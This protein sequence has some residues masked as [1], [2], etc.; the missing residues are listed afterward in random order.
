MSSA[1]KPVQPSRRL[2]LIGGTGR[3]GSAIARVLRASH[4]HL[5]I[6]I[7]G[8]HRQRAQALIDDLEATG[9]GL[10]AFSPFDL[11][12]PIGLAELLQAHDLVVNAAGPFQRSPPVVLSYCVA[13]QCDYVDISDDLTYSAKAIAQFGPAAALTGLKAITTTGPFPG[14]SNVMA[15]W[16][17]AE[18]AEEVQFRYYVAGTGGAGP[19]VVTTT[20]MLSMEPM[21]EYV[22]GQRRYATS[23]TAQEWVEFGGHVGL[24]PTYHFALPEVSTIHSN[25]SVPTVSS[26]F[27]LAPDC[28][29]WLT[30]FYAAF[31]WWAM[32][33]QSRVERIVAASMPAIRYVDQL[34]G[35]A[36]GIQVRVKL[37]PGQAPDP[38]CPWHVLTFT[39]PDSMQC[40]SV[41]AAAFVQEVLDQREGV[42][43]G[44]NWP[45]V[46]I[47]EP[48]GRE[49]LL[50]RVK[51]GWAEGGGEW[52]VEWRADANGGVGGRWWWNV[53]SALSV[54]LRLLP[55]G[56]AVGAY[57]PMVSRFMGDMDKDG[58]RYAYRST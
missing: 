26:K 36:I 4:P 6:V 9:S 38:R 25:F 28:W 41:A 45:E 12:Q 30:W 53:S 18:E 56:R 44:V 33:E 50:Q 21:L 49:R 24:R 22:R 16:L 31:L 3:V 51:K 52:R 20:Y 58:S 27:G 46:A 23:M 42:K 17:G 7:L 13:A 10:A 29:N 35:S 57:I 11:R 5:P 1:A 34:V 15:A 47:Q 40:I 37:R 32:K 2:V 48:G 43:S 14:V 8:R 19:T 39:A 55:G 54:L